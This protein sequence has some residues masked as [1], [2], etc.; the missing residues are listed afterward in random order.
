MKVQELTEKFESYQ[1]TIESLQLMVEEHQKA[2]KNAVIQAE[3]LKADLVDKEQKLQESEVIK[4][5]LHKA[6][7]DIKMELEENISSVQH[8]QEVNREMKINFDKQKEDMI[9]NE[10]E[11]KLQVDLELEDLRS[12]IKNLRFQ[13]QDSITLNQALMV[14]SKQS[15]HG[16]ESAPLVTKTSRLGSSLADSC[17]SSSSS[18]TLSHFHYINSNN[19]N[20]GNTDVYLESVSD[21]IV[22]P[23]SS[24]PLPVARHHQS[25]HTFNSSFQSS[26]DLGIES[27]R[28]RVSSL[29]R[30]GQTCGKCG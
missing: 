27:D 14:K 28:S 12:E 16:C 26:P 9:K 25:E 8:L 23:S 29:E 24:L 20:D 22:G 15:D 1:A 11:T 4:E 19:V 21:N 6:L 30:N 18:T 2:S 5:Q 13:L 17:D 7:N 3:L 10:K